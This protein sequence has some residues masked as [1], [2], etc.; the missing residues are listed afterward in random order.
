MA[1]YNLR[2]ITDSNGNYHQ[3]YGVPY[4]GTCS[5]AAN[6]QIKQV[7]ISDFGSNLLTNGTRIIVKFTSAQNYDGI[8][9]LK[10]NNTSAYSIQIHD[11]SVNAVAGYQEWGAGAILPFVYSNG[12]WIIEDGAHA[13]SSTYGKVRLDGVI[14]RDSYNAPTT[15][16]VSTGINY[17]IMA[18]YDKSVDYDDT[19]Q[20][21]TLVNTST[22]DVSSWEDHGD[23][24]S[25]RISCNKANGFSG[26]EYSA[27][28]FKI[29]VDGNVYY[30]HCFLFNRSTTTDIYNYYENV[31]DVTKWLLISYYDGDSQS[32]Y[33]DFTATQNMA[34]VHTIKVEFFDGGL[35]GFVSYPVLTDIL[36]ERIGDIAT[37]LASI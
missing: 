15:D 21:Q 1:T 3:F 22:P 11:G 28:L 33:I 23:F 36:D 16:A 2:G 18:A 5:T 17:I 27:Q 10:V 9:Y 26:G 6:T 24:F 7:S 30:K 25:Y 13:G 29:T 20:H 4:F 31:D 19:Y 34:D 32:S 35:A 12:H 8:P 37:I 14:K